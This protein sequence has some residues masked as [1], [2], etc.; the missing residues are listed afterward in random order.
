MQTLVF[1]KRSETKALQNISKIDM[2]GCGNW[3]KDHYSIKKNY[4]IPN[5]AYHE[6]MLS[7]N[8]IVCFKCMFQIKVGDLYCRSFK[9]C[10][11]TKYYHDSC[12]QDMF[13]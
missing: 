5:S 1:S 2:K 8:M 7:L 9:K 13:H 4:K 12:Y 6:K 3:T 10:R 11:I